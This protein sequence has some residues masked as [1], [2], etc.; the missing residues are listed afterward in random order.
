LWNAELN[1]QNLE[2]GRGLL[3]FGFWLLAFGFGFG[4]GFG[5][6]LADVNLDALVEVVMPKSQ[7]TRSLGSHSVPRLHSGKGK[8]A[9]R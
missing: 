3:A 7:I 6:W 8:G 5:F 4:F 9:R 2:F 1:T